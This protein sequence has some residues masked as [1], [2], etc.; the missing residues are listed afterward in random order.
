M[1]VEP[2]STGVLEKRR[3]GEIESREHAPLF[4]ALGIWKAYPGVQA[5]KDV[6]LIIQPGEVHGLVGENGAGKTTL[7]NVIGGVVRPDAGILRVRGAEVTIESPKDAAQHGIAVVHQQPSLFG[8]LDVASNLYLTKL[9]EAGVL[10]VP[11]RHLQLSARQVLEQVG[12]GHVAPTRRLRALTP[13]EQQLVEI[14]RALVKDVQLLVLDEPTSSLAR[15]EIETLFRII[16]QLTQEGVSVIYVSHRLEEVFEICDRIT[17]LRDGEHIITTDT[18]SL[19]HAELVQLILGR[20]VEEMVRGDAM[21]AVGPELL[22]VEGISLR[23]KLRDVSFSLHQGEIIGLAGLL[24]TGRTELARVI[25]GLQKP[26]A[27]RIYIHGRPVQIASPE[28]A[29]RLGIGYITEDRHNEGLVLEKS[30]KDNIV[31]ASLEAVATR[32]GWVLP[33]REIEAARRQKHR[34]NII[35]PSLERKVKFL[36]GGNQQKVVLSKWLETRPEIFLMDE[37]T[38]GVDVGA[39]AEFYKIIQDLAAEGAAILLITTEI[40]ELVLLC[41]RVLVL[42]D[43]VIT[44]EFSGPDINPANILMAMTGGK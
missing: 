19:N 16:R 6:S 39:K 13:A 21:R 3:A 42:R 25:F 17:V 32:L 7:V 22:R 35:T 34:L 27:G 29:I 24:G 33:A 41:D 15:R 10:L 14:G 30:V 8:N 4:E 37:P 23:P 38:R 9:D 5:L 40:R 18:S 11:D 2:L 31:M 20:Q 44:A 36:S 26:E 12:L 1:N 28:Q 43:G